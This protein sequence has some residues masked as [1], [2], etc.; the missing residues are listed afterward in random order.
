MSELVKQFLKY[1][2]ASKGCSKHTIDNYER[3]L[4]G[5][6]EFI[7]FHEIKELNQVDR[8]L[9]LMYMQALKSGEVSG[10]PLSQRSIARKCSSLRSFYRY[11]AIHHGIQESPMQGIRLKMENKKLPEFL[12]FH[13][14]LQLL[15]SFDCTTDVGLRNRCLVEMMYACGLRVSE[16]T[17][18]RLSQLDLND[19][20]LRVHGKGNK[21]RI[22]PFYPSLKKRLIKYINDVRSGWLK[23]P[24]DALFISRLGNPL[25]DRTVQQMVS[26]AGE[27]ISL[28]LRLHPHLLRHSFATHMLDNGADLRLVQELLGHENLSSTQIYTHISIDRLR[29]AIE[30]GHPHSIKNQ[31]N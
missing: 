6:I 23:H 3:D 19:L 28:P 29:S 14:V 11:L 8:S 25:S 13:Q 2:H 30:D 16:L 17:S 9:F 5:Y 26:K 24:Q 22:V 4:N 27:S 10:K 21:E 12:T 18:I 31:Q 20:V 15:E 7:K 1:M